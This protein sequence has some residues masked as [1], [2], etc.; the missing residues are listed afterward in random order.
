MKRLRAVLPRAVWRRDLLLGALVTAIA[1]LELAVLTSADG[2]PLSWLLSNLV[3]LP[4]LALRRLRPLAATVVAA[5]GFAFPVSPPEL[6]VATPFL[7]LIFL[8]ASLGWHASLRDGAIGTACVLAAGLAR[9]VTSQTPSLPDTVVNVVVIA[10]SWLTALLLRRAADR[11]VAAEIMA[12]RAAREAVATERARITRD[13]HDSMGHALTLITVQ[14]GSSRE[15]ATDDAVRALLG[16]IEGTARSALDDLHRLLRLGGSESDGDG[17]L[18]VAALPDLL[19]RLAGS[20]LPVELRDDLPDPLPSSMSTA[21]YR[22]TQEGLT[23]VLRHSDSPRARV[24]VGRDD[25]GG[26]LVRVE[27]DG[28]PR[29]VVVQRSGRGVAGLRERVALMGGTV[30]SGPLDEGWLLEARIPW[31]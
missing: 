12:D 23:N 29:P 14:A 6:G 19:G 28:P 7:V 31:T 13:L 20:D 2:V 15:R 25:D 3:L 22:V 18:G 9:E 4:A 8:L 17:A 24:R 21:V 5:L 10:G 26:V 16:G 27:D 30:E 11:R 1:Q